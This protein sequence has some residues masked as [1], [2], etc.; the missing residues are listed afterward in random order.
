MHWLRNFLMRTTT[1]LVV[2]MTGLLEHRHRLRVMQML[3]PR[4]ADA[5]E[6]TTNQGH[7][8][9]MIHLRSFTWVQRCSQ[10]FKKLQQVATRDLVSQKLNGTK[11]ARLQTRPSHG[12]DLAAGHLTWQQRSHATGWRGQHVF[13]ISAMDADD[14]G[15]IEIVENAASGEDGDPTEAKSQTRT[16]FDHLE[17]TTWRHSV[18]SAVTPRR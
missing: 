16:I 11:C 4:S 6:F 12:C 17:S 9:R 3:C 13:E 8:E 7:R 14:K 2:R 5:E 15:N 18:S 10:S 1:H